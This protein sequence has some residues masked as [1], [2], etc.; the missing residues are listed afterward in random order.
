MNRD[1]I[2]K[3]LREP[4]QRRFVY[5]PEF[6]DEGQDPPKLYFTPVTPAD[7][8]CIGNM[9]DGLDIEK[10]ERQIYSAL[11]TLIQKFE[12]EDGEKV[13]QAGEI[14]L[15]AQNLKSALV[16]RLLNEISLGEGHYPDAV[17]KAKKGSGKTG[18]N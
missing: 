10:G 1:F 5:V 8:A 11:A 16:T 3:R 18:K 6:A 15:M 9:L 2:K 4:Q 13:F 17:E 14:H 12:F 7:E